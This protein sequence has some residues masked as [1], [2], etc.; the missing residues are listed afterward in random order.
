MDIDFIRELREVVA[1]EF[2]LAIDEIMKNEK[3]T[4]NAEM[5]LHLCK[6]ITTQIDITLQR[7]YFHY[8]KKHGYLYTKGN[9]NIETAEES[10]LMVFATQLI[11]MLRTFIHNEEIM[12]HMAS[13]TQ[14]GKY[15]TSAFIPQSQVLKSLS[16]VSN[17]AVGVTIAIQKQ[18]IE[19]HKNDQ[20]FSIQRKNMWTQVEYLAKPIVGRTSHKIDVRKPGAKDA[21]WAYQ[22]LKKDLMVYIAYHGKNYTKYYDLN[23]EG[24]REGLMAFNNGWLWEWYNKI[25]YGESEIEYLDTTKSLMI[26]SLRPIILGPD[27]IPGTKEGDFQDLYGRQIQSKYGNQKIISY[28]NIR[29]IIYDLEQSLTTYLADSNNTSQKLVDVL[30]EHFFPESA[31]IG[32]KLAEETVND[33]LNKFDKRKIFQY[34]INI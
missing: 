2:K 22:S 21:H 13:K 29:H 10:K 34:N 26:G 9:K 18:L 23:G 5:I 8:S 15:E 28:N 30:Q 33:L 3:I 25:L 12:F 31:T 7:H 4:S 27:Y 16:S 14:D 24:K 32:G 6:L 17:K 20:L 11:Y 1:D 19:Q